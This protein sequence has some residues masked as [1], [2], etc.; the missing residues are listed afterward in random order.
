MA[1]WKMGDEEASR[2]E[3]LDNV[4]KAHGYASLSTLLWA[5][6]DKSEQNNTNESG[7][8]KELLVCFHHTASYCSGNFGNRLAHAAAVL[9]LAKGDAFWDM[10]RVLEL[11]ERLYHLIPDPLKANAPT[12]IA[13]EKLL[14]C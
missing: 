4:E 7:F 9:A 11:N 5:T 2:R 1:S 3:A 10:H 13:V 6:K 14:W 8:E 12:L